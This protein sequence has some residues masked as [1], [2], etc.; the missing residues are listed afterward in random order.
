VLVL[1]ALAAVG[2]VAAAWGSGRPSND[3]D[4]A[5]DH[6]R[7]AT[8][9]RDRDLVRIRNV[10][11]FDHCPQGGGAPVER[12]ETRVLDLSALDSVWLILSPFDRD[13]RGAAHPFLSF[14]FRDTAFVAISVEARREQDEN[15]SI[16]RGMA[17]EYEMIYVVADER[18]VITLRVLCR[19]DDVYV[20][21]LR[22]GPTRARA[23]FEE[24]LGKVNDLAERPEFYH[25]LFN[26]C[27]GAVLDHANA[28]ADEP[29][30]GGW[31][32]LLPG[33]S[34]EIVYS[35][36]LVDA[37]GSLAEIRER[38]LVN[39]LVRASGG[40]ADLSTVIR[41]GTSP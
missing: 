26:N 11:C 27:A 37:E 5:P 28:V 19:D 9:D 6:A 36:G 13:R 12:W 24:M 4:W 30:P 3:R 33:Y 17:N 39:D 22:V 18:D 8:A 29:L 40:R 14:G 15:Y 34:D 35:L 2:V 7:V 41:R 10:R 31:R 1:A 16:W 25:T 23:L 32:I 38:F 20:Y 21:P